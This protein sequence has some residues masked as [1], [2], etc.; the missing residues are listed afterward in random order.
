MLLTLERFY[1]Y[2]TFMQAS[3]SCN[4][5]SKDLDSEFVFAVDDGKVN[6]FSFTEFVQQKILLQPSHLEGAVDGIFSIPGQKILDFILQFDYD[7]L[8]I[9]VDFSKGLLMLSSEDK[10]LKAAL[11]ITVLGEFHPLKVGKPKSLTSI[12]AQ[13]FCE[14]IRKTSFCCSSEVED[15]ESLSC[16]R[17][18][19]KDN[20]I[21]Y[22]ASDGVR[23]AGFTLA[24]ENQEKTEIF[25]SKSLAEALP[26]LIYNFGVIDVGLYSAHL[27]VDWNDI[28]VI[29]NLQKVH[30]D[31]IIK[32]IM[33]WIER[34]NN[35]TFKISKIELNKGVKIS[36]LVNR[37]PVLNMAFTDKK[38]KITSTDGNAGI[39]N[40]LVLEEGSGEFNCR[41][42]AKLIEKALDVFENSWLLCNMVDIESDIFGLKIYNDHQ[43]YLV[44][45]VIDE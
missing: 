34:P 17:L 10:T 29:C 18:E 32:D 19:F 35:D 24:H 9:N 6:L 12:H 40:E 26:K 1:A 27:V 14:G 37:N 42:Y 21:K 33:G 7:S 11:P 22:L 8:M 45:P 43:Q 44:F 16:V 41:V 4:L 20:E 25:M 31:E 5:K 39:Q 15:I 36:Q 38:L 3:K 13:R 28:N 23:I 30:E 2:N